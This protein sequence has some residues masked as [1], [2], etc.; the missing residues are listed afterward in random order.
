M[1]DFQTQVGYQP[2]PAVEGD[3][4]STNPRAVVLA[5]PGGLIAG[6]AGLVVGR[7]AWLSSIY[8][9]D[10]SA[11]AVAN[12][13]GSGPV[14]G[15]VHREQQA[16]ISQYLQSS[17][18]TIPGGFPVTLFKEGDF[19]VKNNGATTAL[20]GQ[21]CYA[22]FADGKASFA[23]TGAA[24]TASVTGSIAAS[25]GSFT[26]AITGNVLTITAVGSGVA[27]PGGLL[28]GTNVATG[29]KIVSQ[30][31]GTPGGIGTYAVNIGEQTVASTTISETY[32]TMTVTAV[33]SGV[34]GVGDSLS[35]TN[36]TAGSVLTALGTGTGGTGTYIVDG[37]QT[38]AS[39]TITA[40][41]SVETAWTA[42]SQ[43]LVGELVKISKWPQ[44]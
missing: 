34:L 36:V 15:F 42:A 33:S 3:F 9:D 6:A 38:A 35:G 12:N 20:V 29:T 28:S 25:T 27:V 39:A 11:P 24:A 19:W 31:S 37:T 21:K 8:L 40:A 26:G 1:T 7:F 41:T 43:G 14:A 10:D 18:M 2:S 4:A 17:S 32:G 22:N 30:L 23:A 5:G 16:L 13:T 44:G